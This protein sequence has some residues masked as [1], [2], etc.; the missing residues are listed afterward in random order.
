[1]SSTVADSTG[2]AIGNIQELGHLIKMYPVKEIIFCEDGLSFRDIIGI[3]Q[4]LPRN[5]RNK[6]HA[7]GSSSIVGSDDKDISGKYVAENTGYIIASP[8]SKRNKNLLDIIVALIFLLSFP[9]H[10]VL[11][12]KPLQFF[13]NLWAILLRRKT[14]V[15]YAVNST[16]LP[17]IKTGIITSTSLPAAING[18]PEESLHLSDEWYAASYSIATDINTIIR[19][20]QYLCC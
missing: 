12:K 11:Q 3:I 14:W 1:V 8:V 16:L 10:L 7:S 20:Y 5:L 17:A 4:Q 2:T 9:L 19:G 15:G 6:F 13:K 18:L